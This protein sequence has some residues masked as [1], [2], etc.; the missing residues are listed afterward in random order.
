MPAIQTPP[1]ARD[2]Q[3]NCVWGDRLQDAQSCAASL[4]AFLAAIAPDCPPGTAWH[5]LGKKDAIVPLPAHADDVRLSVLKPG[6]GGKPGVAADAR[7][8]EVGFHALLVTASGDQACALQLNWGMGGQHAH[9]ELSLRFP[10]QSTA[11]QAWLTPERIHALFRHCIA[12]WRPDVAYVYHTDMRDEDVG[13]PLPIYWLAYN[14]A[15]PG[16]LAEAL[17]PLP[18]GAE[19]RPLAG[20]GA[21][22]ATTA[23]LYDR[24]DDAHRAASEAVKARLKTAGLLPG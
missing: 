17:Q 15:W 2:Y 4:L 8:P 3:L 12:F 23:G 9:N 13:Y 14:R 1:P 11:A 18:E 21:Y 5:T 10:R 24:F 16:A 6:N 22:L 7:Y 20:Q 19:V